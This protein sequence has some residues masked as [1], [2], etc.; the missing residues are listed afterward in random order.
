MLTWL[1]AISFGLSF[2]IFSLLPEI[3][4][5]FRHKKQWVPINIPPYQTGDDYHYYSTLNI[6]YSLVFY[7]SKIIRNQISK[8]TVN[9]SF[10]FLPHLMV[11]IIGRKLFNSRIAVLLVRFQAR[12]LA[13]ILVFLCSNYLS[14][15]FNI[16][17]DK[18]VIIVYTATT[19]FYFI[20]YPNILTLSVR[21]SIGL[22][23]FDKRH[24][25]NDS[26]Q[27]D[28]FRASP[29]SIFF[30]APLIIILNFLNHSSEQVINKYTFIIL[31]CTSFLTAC[32]PI[33]GL[34]VSIFVVLIFP[35]YSTLIF[36][37]I[38]ILICILLNKLFRSDQCGKEIFL[39]MPNL[40]NF[41]HKKLVLITSL[42]FLSWFLGIASFFPSENVYFF[43]SISVLMSSW[44][45][46]ILSRLYDRGLKPFLW[47]TITL[48]AFD[49]AA[50]EIYQD[51]FWVSIVVVLIL[52]YLIYIIN[53]IVGSDELG[54]YLLPKSSRHLL[55]L[56]MDSN[57][58][59]FVT[60]VDPLS[61]ILVGLYSKNPLVLYYFGLSK[62][63][64]R[65][66]LLIFEFINNKLNN[67]PQFFT[68]FDKPGRK[69]LMDRLGT[70]ASELDSITHDKEFIRYQL[71]MILT[72][73]PYNNEFSKFTELKRS[74][75]DNEKVSEFI[76]LLEEVERILPS[77]KLP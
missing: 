65:Q 15:H 27:M 22:H 18:N 64:W 61:I 70:S 14:Q 35:S 59:S 60:T 68:L 63:G 21:R 33:L 41:E 36:I 45:D 53:Q 50:K 38:S 28:L 4:G 24:A 73:F 23:F 29:E 1:L 49:I 31:L 57:K 67:S 58:E 17:V 47:L 77:Y 26:Q 62:W 44:K 66:N 34:G 46:H 16:L 12:F 6:I 40:M 74:N 3:S 7:K 11:Y 39:G 30:L 25:F 32:N 54:V 72:Y 13:Y 42:I 51:L 43:T 2:S 55:P 10:Q 69:W 9:Q 20:F 56:M 52:I 37:S 19:L 76:H 48:I 71:W 75:F 5:L 8:V